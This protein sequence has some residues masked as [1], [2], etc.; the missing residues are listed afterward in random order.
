MNG[1]PGC[2]SLD[3]L[4][5]ENGPFRANQ[6]G[7]LE[8]T[9]TGWSD[10]STILYGIFPTFT[11]ENLVYAVLCLVD[12]PVGTGFSFQMQ[13]T[14]PSTMDEATPE[15]IT[16]L[17]QFFHLFPDLQGHDMYLSGESYAGVYV[18]YYAT[19]ILDMNQRLDREKASM[20]PS[21]RKWNLKG[22][23]IGNGWLDSETQYGAY[24]DFAVQHQLLSG[25]HLV[26]LSLL[27][28]LFVFFN[29]CIMK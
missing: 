12:Q 13:G 6:E 26:R 16:F 29:P 7:Q 2:S 14:L 17:I 24:V 4:L 3:G 9:R 23:A 19:A 15:F 1:G 27:I 8:L 5:L 18:P 10:Y 21:R 22:M 11:M 25:D 28:F 20:D